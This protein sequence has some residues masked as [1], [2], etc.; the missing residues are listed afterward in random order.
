MTSRKSE[1]PEADWQQTGYHMEDAPCEHVTPI[2]DQN[3]TG[4][5]PGDSPDR[6][7]GDPFDDG[8]VDESLRDMRS[9]DLSSH[10]SDFWVGPDQ[11]PR[12]AVIERARRKSTVLEK[13]RKKLGGGAKMGIVIA[14]AVVLVALAAVL[15]TRLAYRIDTV[16]VTGNSLLTAEEVVAISGIRTGDNILDLKEAD[17]AARAREAGTQDRR[18]YLRSVTVEKELPHRVTLNV[19]ERVPTACF[20]Y[21]GNAYVIDATGFVLEKYA[22]DNA[23]ELAGLIRVTGF[24][25]SGNPF[26]GR[27]MNLRNSWQRAV[28]SEIL[29]E[30]RAILFTDQIT[31]INLSA[32]KEIYLTTADGYFVRIGPLERVHAKLRACDLV[33]AELIKMAKHGGTIDVTTPEEPRWIPPTGVN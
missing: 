27:A 18:R 6:P 10:A 13:V 23:P 31:E 24:D 17:V 3:D 26:P 16:A 11:A 33:R 7:G 30:I 12:D 8:A 14:A 1:R 25:V 2:N 29:V 22:S 9:E 20:V 21:N 15:L 28:Y 5:V 4:Y 19:T 32:E